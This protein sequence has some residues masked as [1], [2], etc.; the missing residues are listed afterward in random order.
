MSKNI[1]QSLS[2]ARIRSA[3]P[4]EKSY[5]LFDR[6]GLGLYLLVNPHGSK[7][8]LLKY[9]FEGRDRLA[10]LGKYPVITL[11]EARKRALELRRQI[12]QGID[13][14][15]AKRTAK[16]EKYTFEI[17]AREWIAQNVSKWTPRHTQKVSNWLDRD[18]LPWLGSKP[19]GSITTPEILTVL[20]RVETTGHN[21]KAHCIQ[22]YVANV[23]RYAVRCGHL[24]HNPAADLRGVLVPVNVKSYAAI[25]EPKAVAA[26]MRA[27]DGY[28]GN[29]VVRC[30]IRL[31]PLVFLRPGELRGA[32]WSELDLDSA[33][34]RIPARRMKMRRDHVVPLSRQAIAIFEEIRPLTGHGKFVFPSIRTDERCIS[35]NTINSALRRLGYA[36][37]EMTGHGF[38]S[39]ASTLLNELGH[40]PD[41]IERQLA[42][43][44]TGVRAVYHRAEHLEA[45]RSM[46][47]KWADYLDSLKAGGEVIGINSAG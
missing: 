26:L 5:K 41:L 3:K 38:R 24:S 17:A 40:R 34:W 39:M 12:E 36:H 20:R 15:E 33:T 2:D 6:G 43:K 32:E 22:E 18:V 7:L 47:Q 31:A 19:V 45:R 8:W 28:Q 16:A 44:E 14:N 13:P 25:T 4:K 27:I 11:S 35:E 37:D 9:K 23:F 46:M 42:H 10:S 29:F 1:P 21:E 30:A